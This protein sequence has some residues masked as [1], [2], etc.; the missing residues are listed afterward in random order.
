MP[1]ALITGSTGFIGGHLA[2][3]LSRRGYKLRALVRDSSKTTSKLTNSCEIVTGDLESYAQLREAVTDVDYVF[4]C[5]AN[6]ST[7]DSAESYQKA[8]VDGVINICRAIADTNPTLKRLVHLSTVDVYDFP[9]HPANE[10]VQLD[11][12]SFSYGASKL[13]GERRLTEVLGTN[14]IPFCILRPCNVIGSGSPFIRRI[15][16]ALKRGIMLEIDRGT[17]HAGFLGI[18]TLIECMIWAAESQ[19]TRGQT[20]NVRNPE[21]MNWHDFLVQ[22]KNGIQGRGILFNLPYSGAK[23]LGTTLTAMHRLVAPK[24]EPL[25][26]PLVTEI[27]GKTCGHS[28]DKIQAAGAPIGNLSLEQA[29]A[30]SIQWYNQQHA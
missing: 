22:F 29:I 12:P 10:D 28:I 8:N 6:V 2:D 17:Q 25:W 18:Q 19:A 1:S 3:E 27:F 14:Q 7:W 21:D 15:G 9:E 24:K 16:D 11:T 4:H 20:F 26:H 23:A 5:A 13:L 30:D